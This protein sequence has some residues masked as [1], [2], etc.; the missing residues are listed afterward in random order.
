MPN[1]PIIPFETLAAHFHVPITEASKNLGVC[2]TVLKKI[3]RKYGIQRWPHRKIKSLERMIEVLQSVTVVPEE[4]I[5][6]DHEIEVVQ[7][8]KKRILSEPCGVDESPSKKSK[9]DKEA[10]NSSNPPKE[11]KEKKSTKSPNTSKSIPPKNT[12]NSVAPEM[13]ELADVALT[14]KDLSDF[15]KGVESIPLED[16]SVIKCLGV[17]PSQLQMALSPIIKVPSTSQALFHTIPFGIPIQLSQLNISFDHLQLNLWREEEL[18]VT[19]PAVKVEPSSNLNNRLP[20]LE[21][22]PRSIHSL[23]QSANSVIQC[24]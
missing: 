17:D 23:L 12:N 2:A 21:P 18:K 1:T 15:D 10:D 7:K 20:T 6:I 19:L 9:K 13:F 8:N 11:P 16:N 22:N 14:L 3:C 24:S 4:Q 5:R